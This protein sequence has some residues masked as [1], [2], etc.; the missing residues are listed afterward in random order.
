MRQARARTEYTP[1]T[2][3]RSSWRV[4]RRDGRNRV[5]EVGA[6]STSRKPA[7]SSLRCACAWQFI[8]N[9]ARCRGMD[10][11]TGEQRACLAAYWWQRA[12]GEI[13]SWVG[14]QHVLEDL[15]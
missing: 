14:F 2:K 8:G 15:R 3:K 9:A 6:S 13:T 7:Q 4:S 10:E 11:L 5:K 12:E 1:R